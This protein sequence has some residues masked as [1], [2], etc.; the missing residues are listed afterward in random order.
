MPRE[1][2]LILLC[3]YFKRKD[4]LDVLEIQ[5]FGNE[6]IYIMIYFEFDLL[7]IFVSFIMP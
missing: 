1:L 3:V 2:F 7:C 4:Y 5:N 6:N